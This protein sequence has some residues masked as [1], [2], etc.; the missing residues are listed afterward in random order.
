[1]CLVT[2]ISDVLALT[3]KE[4]LGEVE[5]RHPETHWSAVVDPLL[6]ELQSTA[7]TVVVVVVAVAVAVAAAV[8]AAAAAAGV[9][10]ITTT[11]HNGP[12]RGHNAPQQT[13]TDHN[14]PQ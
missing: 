11:D 1:M 4:W 9:W 13:T 10:L 14:G 2:V 7:S 3:S 12:Q 8:A 6:E 5:A